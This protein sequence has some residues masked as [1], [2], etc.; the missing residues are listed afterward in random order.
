MVG[1]VGYQT[2]DVSGLLDS[3]SLRFTLSYDIGSRYAEHGFGV[4]LVLLRVVLEVVSSD[5]DCGGGLRIEKKHIASWVISTSSSI[6][7]EGSTRRA[8][9]S[10]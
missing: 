4:V 2:N 3:R 8:V 10:F 6:T 1:P 9:M 7:E 5:F